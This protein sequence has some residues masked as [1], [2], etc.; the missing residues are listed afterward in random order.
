MATT[1]KYPSSKREGLNAYRCVFIVRV[2]V[3]L[4]MCICVYVSVV[5]LVDFCPLGWGVGRMR[6]DGP[7]DVWMYAPSKPICTHTHNL[8]TLHIHMH[9]RYMHIHIYI[10][11]IYIQARMHSCTHLSGGRAGQ[12]EV[13]ELGP[14]FDAAR[15]GVDVQNDERLG[16]CVWCGWGG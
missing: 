4:F 16:L 2:C 10:Y 11:I 14:E 5:G 12:G 1:S 8:H 15:V 9:V 6:W 3:G 7:M 13:G